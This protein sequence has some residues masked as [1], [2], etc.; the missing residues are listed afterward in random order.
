[1]RPSDVFP[2]MGQMIVVM[3]MIR[4]PHESLESIFTHSSLFPDH[5][6]RILDVPKDI[7]EYVTD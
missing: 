2:E 1:M 4:V 7:F 6:E 3:G 5:L